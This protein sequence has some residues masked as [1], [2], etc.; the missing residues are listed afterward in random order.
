M[1][2]IRG[3]GNLATP[4][5][6]ATG[7]AVALLGGCGGGSDGVASSGSQNA[8]VSGTVAGV[9]PVADATITDTGVNGKTATT[10][11][12][13]NGAYTLNVA[14]LSQPI[15]LVATDPSGQ[16]S[17]LVMALAQLPASGQTAIAN[18]TMLITALVALLTPD[19][20]PMDFVTS[21]APVA[22]ANTV[23]A[24]SVS[25]ATSTLDTYLANLL[26]AVGLPATDDPVA[27]AFTADHT[28]ADA[29][30]D[31][32]HDASLA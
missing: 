5:V 14:G 25:N 12:G 18:V 6:V 1:E 17:P 30:I 2:W 3:Q 4:I 22:L 23:I 27:T 20:N 8:A 26:G 16:V 9:N 31:L 10:Q 24:A 15:A 21:G 7:I 11:G 29:L 28:G 32:L 19:G 13:S